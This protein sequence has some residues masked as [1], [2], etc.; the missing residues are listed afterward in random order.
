MRNTLQAT[1]QFQ[2][3]ATYVFQYIPDM[4]DRTNVS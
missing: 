4:R 1:D 2:H 3:A